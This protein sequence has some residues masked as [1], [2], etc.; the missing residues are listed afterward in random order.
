MMSASRMKIDWKDW[1]KQKPKDE[2]GHYYLVW[3]EKYGLRLIRDH[4]SWWNLPAGRAGG[5]PGPRV[6]FWAKVAD[7]GIGLELRRIR[8]QEESRSDE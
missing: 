5:T 2:P 6:R 1:R 4:P 7:P 8:E 3:S